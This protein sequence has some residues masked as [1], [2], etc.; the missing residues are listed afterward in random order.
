M[1]ILSRR[2]DETIIIDDKIEI[3]IVDIK[4]DQVKIGINAPRTVKIY[5][6]EVYLEIEKENAA[7]ARSSA[8]A[9]PSLGD[10]F[11]KK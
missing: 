7:A 2:K 5:R 4:G 9:L 11:K 10:I 3:S 8:E 1:L 6:K